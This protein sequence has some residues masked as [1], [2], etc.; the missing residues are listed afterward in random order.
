MIKNREGYLV[1]DT[2]RECTKCSK[3]FERSSKK[4]ALCN[5]CNSSR[6]KAVRTNEQKLYNGAHSRAKIYDR[7]FT[8][9]VSDIH[10][11]EHCPILGIKL[12]RVIGKAGGGKSSPSLDRKDNS[13]GYT[14]EN[15]WVISKL[16]NQMKNG[17]S[18]EELCSFAK[19]VAGRD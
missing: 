9:S 16:A 4:V 12:E 10:I 17:A 18:D 19:W 15:I 6:V 11:P 5:E 2:H 3:I 7:E 14:P 13:K 8:I 1:S